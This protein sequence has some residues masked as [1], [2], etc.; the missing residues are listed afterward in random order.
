M[1]K[2]GDFVVLPFG[3]IVGVFETGKVTVQVLTSVGGSAAEHS[4][5]VEFDQRL[6]AFVRGDVQP[7]IAIPPTSPGSPENP[8]VIP[9]RPSHPIAIPPSGAHP[10][11]TL[12]AGGAHPD[13]ELPAG[14]ARPDNALP[15]APTTKPTPVPPAQPGTKPVPPAEPKK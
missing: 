14:G 9:G 4:E 15:G 13:N 2:T 11:N 1:A 6:L 5:L 8:I 10:D 3:K 12:P 7:P